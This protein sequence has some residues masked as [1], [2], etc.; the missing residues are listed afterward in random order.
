MQA[1]RVFH[2]I[3]T[4]QQRRELLTRGHPLMPQLLRAL[5]CFVFV[6]VV[7]VFLLLLLLLLLIVTFIL[8]PLL[9]SLHHSYRHLPLIRLA[10][11]MLQQ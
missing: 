1:L 4:R 11:I 9:H 3:Y 8:P 6:V 2:L 10:R 7:I 5:S